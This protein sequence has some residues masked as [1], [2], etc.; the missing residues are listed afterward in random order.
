[1]KESLLSSTQ[2]KKVFTKPLIHPVS[3]ES[4][5]SMSNNAPRFMKCDA[6]RDVK[7][8]LIA[9]MNQGYLCDDCYYSKNQS[10]AFFNRR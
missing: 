9:T 10:F 6:C 3:T 2:E 1:M 5:A 8:S 4:R 7:K